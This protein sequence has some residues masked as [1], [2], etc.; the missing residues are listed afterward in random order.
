MELCITASLLAWIYSYCITRAICQEKNYHMY[1]TVVSC[2]LNCL[3]TGC[4]I[5][6]ILILTL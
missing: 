6:A 3:I 2:I 1:F 4:L 5:I